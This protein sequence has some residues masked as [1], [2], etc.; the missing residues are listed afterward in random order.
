MAIAGS[1]GG[2]GGGTSTTRAS[3]ATA[4]AKSTA[5]TPPASG[6]APSRSQFVSQADAICG[7]LNTAIVA[8]RTKSDSAKEIA[9]VI[10]RNVSLELTALKE[11]EK[12][13]PTAPLASGWQQILNYRR[14]L[15][16]ELSKLVIAAKSNDTSTID[17]LIASKKAAHATL[18][19]AAKPLGFKD[20]SVVG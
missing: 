13:V 12:L 10:P 1:I 19:K 16:D 15:A 18:L 3:S 8:R 2:C 7:R 6:G 11:L 5:S 14:G 20:C 9:R 17:S 4:V